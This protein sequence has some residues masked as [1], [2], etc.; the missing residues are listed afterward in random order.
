MA[1]SYTQN[2]NSLST[3]GLDG[4]DSW[5][6]NASTS[7]GNVSTDASAIFEG[8]KGVKWSGGTAGYYTRS[9]TNMTTGSMYYATRVDTNAGAGDGFFL[10]HWMDGGTTY[11]ASVK[12]IAGAQTLQYLKNTG[13]TNL[14]TSLSTATWYIINME[15]DTTTDQ[16]R[17]RY[18]VAGGSW[19]AYTSWESSYS[20]GTNVNRLAAGI[21]G[22][23]YSLDTISDSDPD[24]PAP[25]T[26]ALKR[27]IWW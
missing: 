11:S 3:A 9:I 10:F 25:T 14:A 12:W 17:F 18:K 5:A 27:H 7:C 15:F 2:W 6:K 13:W 16:V 26:S 19:S 1:Y 8:A 24:T 4:Q 22:G 20:T 21:D 23:A